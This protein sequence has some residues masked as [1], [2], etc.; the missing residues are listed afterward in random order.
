[1]RRRV[2]KPSAKPSALR[3]LGLATPPPFVGRVREFAELERMLREAPLIVV[4]GAIGSGK[5]RFAHEIASREALLGDLRAAYL[6][7]EEGDLASSVIARAERT[8]DVLP[9]SLAGVLQ[10]ERRA[11]LIDDLHNLPAH[12]AAR[13]L[14]AI[15]QPAGAGRVV[16]FTRDS[17]P[18]RRNDPTRSD[19]ELEGLD[20][21]AAHELWAHLE[22]LYRVVSLLG[23][24]VSL[25]LLAFLYQKFVFGESR[26]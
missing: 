23:L 1:M 17:L 25:M 24:G 11:V 5:T 10:Q 16:A 4:T 12:E 8:L 18:L 13:L 3:R 7:C 22:D 26:R 14:G 19:L 20:E 21:I 9:G 6:H 2:S 15:V